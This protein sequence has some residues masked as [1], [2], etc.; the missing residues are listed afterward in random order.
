MTASFVSASLCGARYDTFV[1]IFPDGANSA[2]LGPGKCRGDGRTGS[3]VT[4]DDLRDISQRHCK[5]FGGGWLLLGVD[6]THTRNW[7]WWKK[8]LVDNLVSLHVELEDICPFGIA[9]AT[10]A[11]SG[12]D[13]GQLEGMGTTAVDGFDGGFARPISLLV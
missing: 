3:L 1:L 9:C 12:I 2:P 8:V 6:R 10:I 5:S 11:N 7:G 4:G 13:Y